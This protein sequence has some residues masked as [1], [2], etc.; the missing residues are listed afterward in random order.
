MLADEAMVDFH[1]LANEVNIL[2]NIA[3]STLQYLSGPGCSKVR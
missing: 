2:N 1:V 3:V